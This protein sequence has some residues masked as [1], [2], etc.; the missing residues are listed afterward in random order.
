MARLIDADELEP[1]RFT[2]NEG[3][4]ISQTQIAN[5]P[6]VDAVPREKIDEMIAEIDNL[7]SELTQD[8]RRLIRKIRVFDIIRK[9][10]D[11]EQTNENR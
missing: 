5:A 2:L 7:P 3:L 6:T 11:K 9:Y 1:D 8:G 10:C 4:A